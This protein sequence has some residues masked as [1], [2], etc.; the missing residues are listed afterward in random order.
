M[1]LWVHVV[2]VF[3]ELNQAHSKSDS[4]SLHNGR[5]FRMLETFFMVRVYFEQVR[6][7]RPTQ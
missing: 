2:Q 4:H 7:I 1:L 5:Q 3:N 6:M